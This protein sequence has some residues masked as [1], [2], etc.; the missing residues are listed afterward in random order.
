MSIDFSVVLASSIH[1]IKNSLGSVLHTL[2]QLQSSAG[3]TPEQHDLLTR[4]LGQSSLMNAELI[5]LLCLYRLHNNQYTPNIDQHEV[6]DF[7]QEQQVRFEAVAKNKSLHIECQAD[8][9]LTGFFDR[10]LV[11]TAISTAIHNASR[12]AKT[13]ILLSAY[14]KN[15]FLVIAIE[16]D[17]PGFPDAV[18]NEQVAP[19]EEIDLTAGNTGLGL[20]F[21][22]LVCGQHINKNH[23]GYLLLDSS[24]ALSGA[25]VQLFL[26]L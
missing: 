24:P 20:Y 22:N 5:Q 17:G 8:S 7:L 4:A 26:P 25:R 9:N 1:E 16:D 19:R 2:D 14:I 12:F 18:L 11:S 15:T 10:Q 6:L 3:L 21:S 23:K 13:K